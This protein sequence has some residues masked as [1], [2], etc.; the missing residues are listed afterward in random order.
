MDMR[1][2]RVR[3]I[4]M[5]R[6]AQ[7]VSSMKEMSNTGY[8]LQIFSCRISS[9]TARRYHNTQDSVEVWAIYSTNLCLL[10]SSKVHMYFDALIFYLQSV[11][12]ERLCDE[13]RAV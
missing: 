2:G 10:M 13:E 12:E 9:P 3:H 11:E 8:F 7:K 6:D 4:R 1:S 5:L